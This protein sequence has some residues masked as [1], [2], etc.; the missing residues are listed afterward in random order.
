[1]KERHAFAPERERDLQLLGDRVVAGRFGH[2]PEILS[3][4]RQRL[5]IL[6]PAEHHELGLAIEPRQLPQQVADVGA[7]AEVVQ[8]AGVDADPHGAQSYQAGRAYPTLG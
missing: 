7:D 4:R 6:G 8:L 2:G 1:M 5:A 3:E